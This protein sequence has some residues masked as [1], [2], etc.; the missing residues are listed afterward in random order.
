MACF[1]AA[2]SDTSEPMPADIGLLVGR[3]CGRGRCSRPAHDLT[4]QGMGAPV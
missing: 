4:C 2:G 1:F 3:D